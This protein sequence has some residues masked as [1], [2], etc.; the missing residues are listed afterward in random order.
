MSPDLLIKAGWLDDRTHDVDPCKVQLDA[1]PQTPDLHTIM[2]DSNPDSV[3]LGRT[4]VD[5]TCRFL[6]LKNSLTHN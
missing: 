3:K 6:V 5:D 1:V 4:S 2:F